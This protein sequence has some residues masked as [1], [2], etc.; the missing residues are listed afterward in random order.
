MRSCSASLIIDKS[1]QSWPTLCDP[2]IV[3]H[4]DPLSMGLSREECRSEL[5]F[6]SPGDLPNPGIQPGPPELQAN[7][8]P[9]EP[10]GKPG[11]QRLYVDKSG[12]F[13]PLELLVITLSLLKISKN[14]FFFLLYLFRFP[15][16]AIR[17]LPHIV[18]RI[19]TGYTAKTK[20][21]MMT[22]DPLHGTSL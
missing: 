11:N 2:R 9:S 8:L 17:C 13:C 14:I 7:C 21:N 20:K 6:P 18:Y 3:A 16:I 5:P 22:H 1:L 4:E 10:P 12:L 15:E 19:R